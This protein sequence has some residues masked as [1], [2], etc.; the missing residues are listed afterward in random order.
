MIGIFRAEGRKLVARPAIL[1]GFGLMIFAIVLLEY[2]LPNLRYSDPNYHLGKLSGADLK[3]L[4]LYPNAFLYITLSLYWPFAGIAA[5]LVGALSFG[6]EYGWSTLKTVYTQGP[7]RL[8]IVAA[9][10]CVAVA[11]LGVV[12]VLSAAAMAATSLIIVT[13]DGKPFSWPAGI[14][15]LT[16]L[17]AIWLVMVCYLAIAMA[18]AN[19]LRSPALAI[20]ISLS[21]LLLFELVLVTY[22]LRLTGALGGLNQVVPGTSAGDLLGSLKH[23]E[24]GER[25]VPTVTDPHA[26]LVLVTWT[27]VCAAVSA[28]L[29]WRRD[30]V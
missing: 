23:L 26:I 5:L 24:P 10:F 8:R 9:Q 30:V 11:A 28:A 19:L 29:V 15:V 12:L 13:V 18:L 21:Y 7:S 1:I 25:F 2:V 3:R 22:V 14:D 27:I 20:G 4:E 17:A 6:S 16:G